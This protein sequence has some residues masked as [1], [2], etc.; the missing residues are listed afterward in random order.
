[1]AETLASAA[2]RRQS[3]PSLIRTER[4]DSLEVPG[5]ELRQFFSEQARQLATEAEQGAPINPQDLLM[6]VNTARAIIVFEREAA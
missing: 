6:L 1:M 5:C 2:C 4:S 3:R